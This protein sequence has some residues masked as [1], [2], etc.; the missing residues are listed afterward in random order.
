[1]KL[2]LVRVAL[3]VL[4][5]TAVVF[6]GPWAK[7]SI[8]YYSTLRSYSRDV[9][10]GMSRKQVE[11]YFEAKSV[12]YGRLA[13]YNA[14]ADITL[15]GQEKTYLPF[16]PTDYV[17]I[18]FHFTASEPHDPLAAYPSDKLKNITLLRTGDCV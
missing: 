1:M 8:G 7:R 12:D 4:G 14:Y 3:V 16:C 15:I 11:D 10:P 5:L 6:G 13:D 9:K 17:S 2:P 18:V